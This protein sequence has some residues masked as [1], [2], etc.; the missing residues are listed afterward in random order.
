MAWRRPGDKPIS[1]PMMV[2]LHDACQMS[3]NAK[4]TMVVSIVGLQPEL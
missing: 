1:E 2:S 3:R 4:Y